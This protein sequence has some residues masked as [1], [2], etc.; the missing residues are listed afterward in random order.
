IHRLDKETSGT[1]VFSKTALANRSL[2]AQFTGRTI[3]K[4]YLLLTDRAV[5]H[6]KFT[7][8]SVLARAGDKYVSRPARAGGELAETRFKLQA[9]NSKLQRSSNFQAAKSS[10]AAEEVAY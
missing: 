1:I 5:P 6:E 2:T 4:K 3:R 10:D 8:R 7:V 9:P